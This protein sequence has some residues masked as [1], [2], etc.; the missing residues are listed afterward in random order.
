MTARVRVGVCPDFREE[1]W[2]SMNR[3]ADALVE[4]L[5]RDHSD[6]ITASLVAPPFKRRA[7]RMSNGQA[8]RNFDRGVN[9]LWDYP[10]A[11][12]DLHSKYDVFHVVDH[13]YSQL[14][15]HLPPSRTVVT[16]H[17]LDTF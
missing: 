8:A 15:Q 9:R 3:V 13:S 2:P 11:V 5:E 7:T 10:R 12:G 6:A 1:G 14:V 17:D 4:H 16:C